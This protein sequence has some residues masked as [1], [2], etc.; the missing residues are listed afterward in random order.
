MDAVKIIVFIVVLAALAFLSFA[1]EYTRLESER[2]F[3]IRNHCDVL[4]VDTGTFKCANGKVY[5][6]GTE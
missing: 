6:L 3:I 2:N 1:F 4:D 5:K